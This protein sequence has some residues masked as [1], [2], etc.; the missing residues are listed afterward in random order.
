M[1]S[2][3]DDPLDEKCWPK[4]NPSL[5][6]TLQTEHLI[7]NRDEVKQVP[8][9]LNAFLQY[10]TNVWPEISLQRV[11]SVPARSWDACAHMELIAGVTNPRDACKAFLKL[12][13]GAPVHLGVDVG[14]TSDLTAVAMLFSEPRFAENAAPVTDKKV[15]IVQ[16]FA[17]EDGLLEKEKSWQVPLSQ[18]A[19]EG[20]IQLLP[21]DMIDPRE[22]RKFILD[23]ATNFRV[24]ELGFDDWNARVMCGDI[25]ESGAIKCVA[26]PQ[27]PKELTSPSREFLQAINRKELVH[28]GNPCLAWQAGNVVFEEDEKHGGTKPQK[29]SANEK[30]D[31]I[32]ASINAWHRLLATPVFHSI[33]ETRGIITLDSRGSF[34]E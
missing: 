6:V 18:W 21:G 2:K 15:L 16:C 30:I 25:N 27:I 10:H 7:K 31:G 23:I 3:G 17:P 19:R 32:A 4:A 20:F 34:H 5:G 33:Y 8:S 14:L 12:N 26:V 13:L 22:I 28:F 24:V 29:L 11:G 9:G 1:T